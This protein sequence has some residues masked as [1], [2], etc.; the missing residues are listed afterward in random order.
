MKKEKKKR[1]LRWYEENVRKRGMEPVDRFEY[2]GAKVVIS[3]GFSGPSPNFPFAHYV[4]EWAVSTSNDMVD[5]AQPVHYELFNDPLAFK[6][7]RAARVK[8][9][10]DLAMGFLKKAEN[11]RDYNRG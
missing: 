9:S 1:D 11:V 5:I 4:T 10:R 8:E 6:E 2:R 3:D 7:K